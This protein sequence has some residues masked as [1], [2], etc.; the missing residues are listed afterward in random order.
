MRVGSEVHTPPLYM[1]AVLPKKSLIAPNCSFNCQ[2]V[3]LHLP[4]E[5][6]LYRSRI[7]KEHDHVPW[8]SECDGPIRQHE[9]DEAEGNCREDSESSDC[10]LIVL[11][12]AED[13]SAFVQE[14]R[15]SR[16]ERTMT[17]WPPVFW[18]RSGSFILQ[19]NLKR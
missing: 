9:G 7:K 16:L 3:E 6:K 17:F 5:G 14:W 10:K 2:S 11:S 15:R 12:S 13:G 8:C 18:E 19:N 1:L 4:F